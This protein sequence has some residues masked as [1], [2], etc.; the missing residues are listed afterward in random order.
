M[1]TLLFSINPVPYLYWYGIKGVEF[2]F[3]VSN[4]EVLNMNDVLVVNAVN[5][6]NRSTENLTRKIIVLTMI[7]VV[8]TIVLVILTSVLAIPVIKS[9]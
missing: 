3:I 9:I 6:L 1:S 7:L 2:G 4:L 8:L 5:K